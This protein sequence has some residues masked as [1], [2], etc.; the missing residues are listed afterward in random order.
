MNV[1]RAPR[2]V[3][4]IPSAKTSRGG[5]GAAACLD[6]L[7]PREMT[8]SLQSQVLLPA[9]VMLSGSQPW[10][11]DGQLPFS[12]IHVFLFFKWRRIQQNAQVLVG[13]T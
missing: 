4:F 12:W 13:Y 7:L 5:T 6:S 10:V 9:Q 1:R 11:I 3:V 8:G 2:R